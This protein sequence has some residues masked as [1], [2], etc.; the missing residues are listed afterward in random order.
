[1]KKVSI[2]CISLFFLT[3]I[4]KGQ[5]IADAENHI[6]YQRYE[7]AKHTLQSV[8][9]KDG[10]PI[11]AWYLLGEIYIKQKLLDSARIV[12]LN[13][14]SVF[15]QNRLSK[16]EY[17]LVHIGWAHLLLDSGLVKDS[18]NQ[19]EEV[20]AASRY[21]D[22]VA[23][24]AVAKANTESKNGD[25][26]W[27]IELLQKAI[28]KDKHNAVIY[29]QLGDAYRKIID[30][31]NAISSYNKALEANPA[32]AEAMFKKGQIY[33]TQN[34]PEIYMDR[35]SA[36]FSIDSNYTPVLYELYYYYYFRNVV[37]AAKYLDLYILN[38]DPSP[39][40]AYLKTDLYYVSTKYNEAISSAKLIQAKE[41][42][43]A[44][45][46]LFKLIAYCYA[47]IGDSV[48]ALANLDLYFKNQ[49][50]SEF[51]VKDYELKA[52]LLEKLNPDKLLAIEW[53]KKA[54]AMQIDKR[55]NIDYMV[56]IAE[57]Q[58]ELGN[59][60]RE[61]VWRENIYARKE[62]PSNLDLYKWGMALYSAENYAKADSVFEIYEQKY[63]E[64]IYGYLWRARC[65]ALMDTTME[66]G[67]AVPHYVNLVKVAVKDSVKNSA[68]L[69][70]AYQ[71]LGA[72]EANITKNYSASLEYYNKL[73]SLN[74]DDS[75]A[76]RNAAI[77]RKRIGDSKDK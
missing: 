54:L 65:N 37:K 55:D 6:Y 14:L 56:S 39:Q 73:I 36:A 1:M 76:Q 24:L 27:A 34:N 3:N 22:P 12:L 41:G 63:P 74:P 44:Q 19:M 31:G 4:I 5:D 71:Y 61:A 77:L 15:E 68:I 66:M 11:N 9:L 40:H 7:S 26:Q 57:L 35:F 25:A 32:Y 62:R 18:R 70:R 29:T 60:E 47:A 46:R 13:G 16:K 10:A 58:K 67:L 48:S 42:D 28:K 38:A 2:I 43:N 53:Y 30:G 52:K 69:L 21:K 59:R 45:P 23:L 8:T 51:V 33:K 64:Q 20:L 75:E 49:K 72:Y 17:P 50:P